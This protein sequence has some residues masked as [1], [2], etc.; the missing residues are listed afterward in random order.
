MW[1]ALIGVLFI[2]PAYSQVFT[3]DIS[4]ITHVIAEQEVEAFAKNPTKE[5]LPA[6]F[7]DSLVTEKYINPILNCEEDPKKYKP[8][9]IRYEVLSISEDVPVFPNEPKLNIVV[10]RYKF[11]EE[12]TAVMKSI[13]DVLASQKETPG[14]ISFKQGHGAGKQIFHYL[15]PSTTVQMNSKVNAENAIGMG[16]DQAT[17]KATPIAATLQVDLVNR[18]DIKQVVTDDMELKGAL[19]SL[20][21]TGTRNLD[22][23]SGMKMNLNTVKAEARIDTKIQSNI[24]GY[25]EVNYSGNDLERNVRV[26]AGIDIRIPDQAAEIMVF[27]GYNTR[28][29]GAK[30]QSFSDKD[31]ETEFGVKYKNKN[32]VRVFGRVRKGSDDKSLYETGV[33]IDLR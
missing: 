17:G 11:R 7:L 15:A 16:L 24:K 21:S 2:A 23:L 31:S 22:G 28:Y 19:E 30:T 20:H 26:H 32:G 3:E 14:K 27:S 33:E 6:E 8:L 9:N 5:G 10:A 12:E 29:H 25:S 18:L 4:K 13:K 1:K